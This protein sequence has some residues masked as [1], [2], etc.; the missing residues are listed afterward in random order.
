MDVFLKQNFTENCTV[1]EN[2]LGLSNWH[3]LMET[4]PIYCQKSLISR[5]Q[6]VEAFCSHFTFFLNV[7]SGTSQKNFMPSAADSHMDH[8][9]RT[10]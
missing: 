10:I 7:Q 6:K 9:I 1:P 2:L 4:K 5:A 3:F 8:L